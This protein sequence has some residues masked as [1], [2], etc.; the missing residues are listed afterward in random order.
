[1][2]PLAL[3]ATPPAP[4]HRPRKHGPLVPV[5][6]HGG[7]ALVLPPAARGLPGSRD[8]QRMLPMPRMHFHFFFGYPFFFIYN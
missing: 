7:G 1:M 4:P 3:V 5:A 2:D 8:Q 6:R